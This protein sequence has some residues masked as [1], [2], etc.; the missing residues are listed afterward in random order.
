M[1][2]SGGL[3]EQPAKIIEAYE[4]VRVLDAE[5]EQDRAKAIKLK[6]GQ[7]GRQQSKRRTNR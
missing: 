7:D 6:R 4:M 1:P 3:M 5:L 2:Y